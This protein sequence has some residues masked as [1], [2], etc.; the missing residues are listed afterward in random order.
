MVIPMVTEVT[1][2]TYD[3]EVVQSD[4]P[5]V[6]DFW[7]PW[8][9]PCRMMAPVFEK[10]AAEYEESVKFVK[11]NTDEHPEL[12]A[13]FGV[14]GIPTLIVANKGAEV[15]RHVG[16]APEPALKQRI[17]QIVAQI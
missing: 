14:Q 11:I 2:E 3:A 10:L 17:D 12:A 9:G 4:L 5:V 15:D 13:Q 6:I 16:F 1:K 8:C 7:A